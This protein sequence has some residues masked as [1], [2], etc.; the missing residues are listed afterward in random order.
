ML[1]CC[2]ECFVQIQEK[3]PP[4]KYTSLKKCPTLIMPLEKC[5]PKN[6]SWKKCLCIVV[7]YRFP[8]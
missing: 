6:T 2:A 5:I 8:L 3:I 4:G 7:C 1:K